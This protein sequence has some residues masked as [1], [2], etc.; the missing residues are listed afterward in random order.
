M[1]MVV[2]GLGKGVKADELKPGDL[3]VIRRP[4]NASLLLA[5][6][7][8]NNHDTLD[9]LLASEGEILDDTP[10]PYQMYRSA[11][12]GVRALVDGDVEIRPLEGAK[13]FFAIDDQTGS[14]L[15]ISP[16]G[17]PYVRSKGGHWLNLHDATNVSRRPE[18]AAVYSQ[19]RI[20][21]RDG[22]R[23]ETL[24]TFGEKS[25]VDEVNKGGASR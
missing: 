7:A 2:R 4:N 21:W 16:D 22:E 9:V 14:G 18:G 3:Y 24:A 8:I 11:M 6:P 17:T 1:T 15:A 20:V 23:V 5:G 13:P 12:T 19:W 10:P 25:P